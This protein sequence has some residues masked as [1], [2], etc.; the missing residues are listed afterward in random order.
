M[1]EDKAQLADKLVG[2]AIKQ[3][4]AATKYRK[5]RLTVIQKNEDAYNMKTKPVLSGRVFVPLPIVSGF[6]DTLKSKIDNAPKLTFGHEGLAAYKVAKKVTAAWELESKPTRGKWAQKDRAA[7]TLAIFSG[8]AIY[9]IYSES[10]PT[11]SNNLEIVDYYDFVCEPKGGQDLD[12]HLF[13]GQTNIFRTKHQIEAG[14]EGGLY[15]AENARRLLGSA[16][17]EDKKNSQDV[18]E[19]INRYRS[20]GLDQEF[21]N[22]VGVQTVNMTEWYMTYGGDK[23]Y[24]FFDPVSKIWL[25]VE[26]LREVIESNEQP[27]VSWATNEDEFNFWSKA[28]VDDIR[29]VAEGMEMTFNEGLNNL[30]KRNWG[31]RAYDPSIF[32]DP[33]QLEWTRPDGLVTA[34]TNMGQR[35]IGSGIFEFQTPDNTAITVNL[36]NFLDNYLGKQTGITAGARGVSDKDTKVGV[37]YGDLAQVSDRLGLTNKSYSEAWAKLGARYVSGL[38][39]HLDEPM[40]VKMIGTRGVEWEELKYSEVKGVEDFDISVSGGNSE[41]EANEIKRKERRLTLD[42]ILKN[43]NLASKL[44]PTWSIQQLLSDGGFSQDEV[45]I[46][47]DTNMD[48]STIELLSEADMAV[49]E[50]LKG[51]TPKFNRQANPLFIQYI[52]DF[53]TDNDVTME[54]YQTLTEYANQHFDIAMQNMARKAMLQAKFTPPVVPQMN[55]QG[56]VPTEEPIPSGV[57]GQV[58]SRSQ[59]I[60]NLLRSNEL[61]PA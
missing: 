10:N 6:V 8:R 14:I 43:P 35:A 18:Q 13:L 3:M 58:Q 46:A 48:D 57:G 42:G 23:Y 52:L 21:N 36:V 15:D 34:N 30:R 56:E 39:E 20:L 7:K 59:Q 12:N 40:L 45:K 26:K 31:M 25:R 9:K 61:T 2:I 27:Y 5:P 11:Y 55:N 4:E 22:Y 16:S 54:Q 41:V 60:S 37:Y 29:P 28:P 33:S 51:K 50:I 49:E 24:L 1:V 17:E 47:L 53:A 32:P 44:N 19:K 38:K